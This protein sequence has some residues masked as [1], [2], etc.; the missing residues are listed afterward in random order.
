MAALAAIV[1][2]PA[3]AQPAITM[4]NRN[5][6]GLTADDT[7][8]MHA[9]EARLYEGRSVGT[10]ERWRNPDSDN[11]GEVQ[12]ARQ[13]QFKGMPCRSLNYRVRLAE[14]PKAEEHFSLSW[15][16]LQSGEWKTVEIKPPA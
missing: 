4:P 8:R 1:A 14:R 7:A 2:A 9:A 5:I 11:A 6:S 10:I 13:F 16:K 3:M 15:C 12:L